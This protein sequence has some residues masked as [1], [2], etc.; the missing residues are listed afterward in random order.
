MNRTWSTE[1]KVPVMLDGQRA[2]P[3]QPQL[4]LQLHCDFL[5]YEGLEERREELQ[6]QE[7]DTTD[8]QP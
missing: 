3:T 5:A 1:C 8:S 4:I 6:N 7:E 2:L